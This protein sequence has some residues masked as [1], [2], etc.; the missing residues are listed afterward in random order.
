MAGRA[1]RHELLARVAGHLLLHGDLHGRRIE[2]G[3][4]CLGCG[5]H[6]DVELG[7]AARVAELHNSG[8]EERHRLGQGD[9][10]W[11]RADGEAALGIAPGH[12]ALGRNRLRSRADRGSRAR[13]RWHA[14]SRS[15][16]RCRT[17]GGGGRGGRGCRLGNG[18]CGRG[19]GTL[20]RHRRHHQ[21]QGGHHVAAL[22]WRRLDDGRQAVLQR[23]FE[24][25]LDFGSVVRIGD[26]GLVEVDT[27]GQEL[28]TVEV[29]FP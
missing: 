7:A 18:R 23:G 29:R 6:G 4:D 13:R 3:R 8:T 17:Q 24:R 10:V 9:P 21:R 28:A 16:A 19:R 22:R 14:L 15:R 5:V 11:G 20:G 26:L 27:G 2:L 25:L 1:A 12:Q